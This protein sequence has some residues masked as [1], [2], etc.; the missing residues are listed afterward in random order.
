MYHSTPGIM[1]IQSVS[2]VG[3]DRSGAEFIGNK[4]TNSL[5]HLQTLNFILVQKI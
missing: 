5:T 2:Y 3:V 1:P 4:Q